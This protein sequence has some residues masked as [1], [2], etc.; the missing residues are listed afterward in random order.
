[1]PA[2]SQTKKSTLADL[3][4]FVEGNQKTFVCPERTVL[5][6]VELPTFVP[7]QQ[8]LARHYVLLHSCY[9]QQHQLLDEQWQNRFQRPFLA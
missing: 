4:W 8:G 2:N 7:G 1:M 9:Q 6:L 3:P 5:I